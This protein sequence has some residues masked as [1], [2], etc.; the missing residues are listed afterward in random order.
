[1]A[2]EEEH[3]ICSDGHRMIEEL[4]PAPEC[5]L[6]AVTQLDRAKAGDRLAAAASRL[7]FKRMDM[8]EI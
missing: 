6:F 7:S 3:Q 8:T 5:T 4:P 2:E 1:M